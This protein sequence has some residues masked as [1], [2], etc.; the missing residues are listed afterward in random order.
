MRL[1]R[2]SSQHRRRL[3]AAPVLERAAHPTACA[4][5]GWGASPWSIPWP[6]RGTAR[7]TAGPSERSRPTSRAVCLPCRSA[8]HRRW[9]SKTRTARLA[10]R[11]RSLGPTVSRAVA[12]P[13][14]GHVMIQGSSRP[15]LLTGIARAVGCAARL[16][17]GG[18]EPATV[19]HRRKRTAAPVCMSA[20]R[21][22]PLAQLQVWVRAPGAS[23]GPAVAQPERPR[24]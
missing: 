14:Q 19:P 5:P 11:E 12:V 13:R 18:G 20:L 15:R 7:E 6:C 8:V 16:S 4:A 22:R 23:R 3:A 1:R 9:C 2:C 10:R 24:G 17:T 21:T